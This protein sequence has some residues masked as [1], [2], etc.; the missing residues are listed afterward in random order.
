MLRDIAVLTGGTVISEEIG[1]KLDSVTLEDFGEA[2]LDATG[3][4]VEHRLRVVARA[5]RDQRAV[6]VRELR[7]RAD[8]A[9]AGHQHMAA[10]H[11]EEPRHVGLEFGAAVALP[12]QMTVQPKLTAQADRAHRSNVRHIVL[13]C[14]S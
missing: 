12:R 6:R 10:G 5:Q 13:T 11:V 1:R 14:C 8:G 4:A 3:K 7:H 9:R 2:T